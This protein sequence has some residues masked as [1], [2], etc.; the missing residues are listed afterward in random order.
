MS[1][2]TG[3]ENWDAAA[4]ICIGAVLAGVALMLG[5]QSRSL[6]I[7]A[8]A[9]PETRERL[10]EIVHSFPEVEDMPRLLSMQLGASSVL[11]TGELQ[12]K[13]EMTTT[14][15]EDLI[16]RIDAKIGVELPEIRETFWELRGPDGAKLVDALQTP[17]EAEAGN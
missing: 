12:V 11:V 1:E 13:R 14:E 15:I 3:S 17:D 8:A 4:S 9:N 5:A 10:R 2:V 16:H 7:G 6:L